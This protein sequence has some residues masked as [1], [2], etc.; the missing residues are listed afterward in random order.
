MAKGNGTAQQCAYNLLRCFRGEVPYER[1][2]GID[3]RLIDKPANAAQAE[4]LSDAEW[5]LET[6]EPRAKLEGITVRGIDSPGG[7]FR[8]V[9]A[10]ADSETG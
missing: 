4:I 9:A 7:D 8:V 5:C 10:V 6:Y 2:K 3:P 1:V